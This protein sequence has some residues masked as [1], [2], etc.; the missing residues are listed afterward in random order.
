M[1]CDQGLG[2][3]T[4]N[5]LVVFGWSLPMTAEFFVPGWLNAHLPVYGYRQTGGHIAH[6][7]IDGRTTLESKAFLLCHLWEGLYE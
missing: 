7:Q 5:W 6:E 4:Y 1:I 2:I 3:V